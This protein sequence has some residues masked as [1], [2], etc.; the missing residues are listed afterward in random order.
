MTL[1]SNFAL[2]ADYNRWMNE[3]L[4][5]AAARLPPVE[6]EAARGA[7]FGSITGTL[8]HLLAADLIWLRRFA[9]HPRAPRLLAELSEWP[10]PRA[11]GEPVYPDFDKLAAARPHLD[12]LI[13][14][15]VAAL[16][17]EDLAV[18]LEYRNM[19]GVAARRPLP[20]VIQHFFNH[21]TH[22]RGQA[23]TLLTQ[24]GEDVGVTDLLMLVA[25]DA[26]A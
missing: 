23:T 8:N 2:L 5:A 22:H 25:N 1:L 11:L 16:R 13:S 24:A 4:Y 3:K 20:G 17:E 14:R 7:F 6:R 26:P 10:V 21:Q 15:W 18:P 19:Q 12:A 9:E